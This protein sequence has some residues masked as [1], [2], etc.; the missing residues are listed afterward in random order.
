MF[1]LL[2]LRVTSDQGH[3][4]QVASGPPCVSLILHTDHTIGYKAEPGA[5]D[6][7]TANFKMDYT[8]I[9]PEMSS[10]ATPLRTPTP[11]CPGGGR[12]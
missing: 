6:P 2:R 9:K 8:R 3:L 11:A 12:V 5:P 1:Y 10:A 7:W 4:Q